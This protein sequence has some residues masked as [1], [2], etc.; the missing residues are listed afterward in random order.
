[1]DA[2]TTGTWEANR[3]GGKRQNF[4]EMLYLTCLSCPATLQIPPS[5]ISLET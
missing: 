4:L 2:T 1:M 5:L 3:K